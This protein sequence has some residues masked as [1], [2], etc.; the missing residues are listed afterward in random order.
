MQC[1]LTAMMPLNSRYGSARR[2]SP[3]RWSRYILLLTQKTLGCGIA[4]VWYALYI[5]IKDSVVASLRNSILCLSRLC[6]VCVRETSTNLQPPIHE[7]D[8]LEL[9]CLQCASV[10]HNV[11]LD[12]FRQGMA[13]Y[14]ASAISWARATAPGSDAISPSSSVR[15]L[16]SASSPSRFSLCS[17][18]SSFNC[19]RQLARLS[20]YSLMASPTSPP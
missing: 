7:Q 20:L 3:S 4:G 2:T 13:A 16:Y 1:C 9:R 14:L 6:G 5:L 12:L 11:N 19:C 17:S 15:S 8:L 10:I 18:T